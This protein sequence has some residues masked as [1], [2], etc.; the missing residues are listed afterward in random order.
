MAVS[1]LRRFLMPSIR[2]PFQSPI[3]KPSL[4]TIPRRNFSSTP[5]SFATY[6]Q[7][8]RGCRHKKKARKAVSPALRDV[9]AP[10]L[11][12]VCVKVSVTKPK[13][14]NSG[15]KKIARG[16]VGNRA[17]SRS[18]YGLKKPKKAVVA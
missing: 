7:V 18:K 13:K 16:G 8:A 6:N 14:P 4:I 1:I 12:G 15:E 3:S 11:K 5:T 2:I 17:T 9:L 10:E